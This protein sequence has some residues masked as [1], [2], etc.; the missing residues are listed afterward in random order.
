[1]EPCKKSYRRYFECKCPG[2]RSACVGAGKYY[3]AR[4]IARETVQYGRLWIQPWQ[5]DTDGEWTIWPCGHRWNY[6][7]DTN[8]PSP[9][10]NNAPENL[11]LLSR[12]PFIILVK[13]LQLRCKWMK[14]HVQSLFGIT[15]SRELYWYSIFKWVIYL[16]KSVTGLND[17]VPG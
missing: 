10:H 15:Q 14:S 2:V 9:S 1:M 4:C 12:H 11:E 13:W 7:L 3:D 17:K 8:S 16:T 6:Y 5:R